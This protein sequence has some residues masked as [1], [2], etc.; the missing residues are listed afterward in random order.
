MTV[1]RASALAALVGAS[2]I[3]AVLAASPAAAQPDCRG[4]GDAVRCETKGSVQITVAPQ[5]RA[6]TPAQQM[7]PGVFWGALGMTSRQ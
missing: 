3:G 1:H 2:L 7:I 6:P 4:T 5:M